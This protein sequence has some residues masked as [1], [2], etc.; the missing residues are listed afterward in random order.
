VQ[1]IA[2]GAWV[3]SSVV[4]DVIIGAALAEGVG[5][6]VFRART[7]R[8]MPMGETVAFLGAGIGLL[9]A[10]RVRGSAPAFAAAMLVSLVCNLWFIWQRK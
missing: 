6:A 2:D 7:G 9:V 8:G 4:L 3:Q 5:L 1:T 10:M